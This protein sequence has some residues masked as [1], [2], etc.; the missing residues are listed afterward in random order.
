MVITSARDLI[1][2]HEGC[3]LTAKP[4]TKGKWSIGYG[5]DIDPPANEQASTCTQE[6]AD[7]F[8]AADFLVACRD[9]SRVLGVASFS[10]LSEP[11]KAA[12]IDMAYELG[13]SGLSEFQKMLGA[14]RCAFWSTARAEAL[15]SEWANEVPARA[16]MDATILLT[17]EW[18]TV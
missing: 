5:H 10:V 14:I 4:D 9:A 2:F 3:T 6:A 8:F 17:G 1:K 13:E 11:R 16:Q 18:P 12:L 15:N 7:Q